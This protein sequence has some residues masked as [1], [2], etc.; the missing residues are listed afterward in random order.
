MNSFRKTVGVLAALF[1]ALGMV[2]PAAISIRDDGAAQAE[3]SDFALVY[4]DGD[5]NLPAIVGLVTEPFA[6]YGSFGLVKA[7]PSQLDFMK[8]LGISASFLTDRTTIGLTSGSFDT[9]DGEPQIPG[10]LR[11]SDYGPSGG[12]YIVQLVGPVKAEWV[13]EM[14]ALGA[15]VHNYLPNCAYV[16]RMNQGVRS[17]VSALDFVQWVGIYQP[18][19]KL[20][21]GLADG[22]FNVVMWNGPTISDTLN[23]LGARATI[24]DSSYDESTDQ[25][26][27]FI[28]TD[29]AGIESIACLPDVLWV[30]QYDEPALADETSSEIVGGIWTANTPYGA[31][32]NYANLMGWNGTGVTVAVADT[33]LSAGT[34]PNA[35][36]QD[37]INRVVGGKDYTGTNWRDGHG[38]GTHCAGIIAACGWNGTGVKYGATQYYC[39]AGVAPSANL[40]GQKIF[41]D[42]GSGTGIPTTTATWGYFFQHAYD[43]GAY[44]H[45]NSWGEN[46]GDGAYEQN[47]I[48]Y[49]NRVRDC[50]AN[51]TGQQPLIIT[52]AAGNAGS[53]QNTVGDPGSAKS[54]ITVAASENYHTD[55]ATYGDLYDTLPADANDI[56]QIISFSSRGWEDDRRI[57]PD[58]AAPGTAIVSTH[59]AYLGNGSAP[60]LYGFYTSD[61]RYEWCS[62][63]SQANPHV[64]GSCAV[65]TQWYTT[66]FG[67]RPMPAM[68]KALLINTAIDMGTA[69]IPNRDEGWG[70]VYLPNIVNAPVPVIRKDNPQLLS[71]GNTYFLNVSYQDAA[72]PMK[73]TLAYTDPAGVVN[74]NPAL[75]NNLNLRVTAPGGGIWYG[76]GFQNGMGVVGRNASNSNFAVYWDTNSDNFD[77]R[78]NVECVYIPTGSLLAGTY[79]I[80]VIAQNVPTDAVSGGAVDQDFALTVYNANEVL[81]QSWTPWINISVVAGWNL[82]SVP[83]NGPTAMPGALQDMVN[84]GAGLVV[85]NRVQAYNTSTPSNIWKQYNTGWAAA[86]NDLAAVDNKMG[87]WINVVTVGDGLLCLGGSGYT[88]ST[89]TPISL[90]VGWNLIGFPSDDAAYTVATFKADCGGLV[91]IVEGFNAVAT[92]RTSALLDTDYMTAGHAYWVYASSATTWTKP[93]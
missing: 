17:A 77:E 76:N 54:V 92:Y 83:Y 70:R 27:A 45:S 90:T 85:W 35:G 3:P 60:N 49:D 53:T 56:N 72:T 11:I 24:L 84:G 30:G 4:F 21:P 65:L 61:H 5:W 2:L 87:V 10:A 44:V 20:N 79:S 41:T 71:T 7:T 86:L 19:Y 69:D 66:T 23:G 57:K 8:G 31:A 18:A 29:V 16:V 28:S 89:S 58:V 9:R 88:N 22:K 63:T 37:F 81:P 38:H 64:A 67:Q 62:G 25:C 78:N 80:E 91:T 39:G 74:G 14:V 68:V 55:G 40:Y 75:V 26:E 12:L 50:A 48:E 51:T 1:V 15:S 46:P 6:D 13:E 32:G 43:A 93:W 34:T 52:V 59:S 73:I 82:V 36:H 42:A 33:G 47:S